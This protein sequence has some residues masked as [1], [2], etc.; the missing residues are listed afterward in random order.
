MG[1]YVGGTSPKTRKKLLDGVGRVLLIDEAYRLA[2]GQ[3]ESEAVNEMIQFLSQPSHQNNTVVI[4]AG[5][6][7]GMQELMGRPALSRIFQ[8][9]I[10]FENIPADDCIV[11]LAKELE[12]YGFSSDGG[13]LTNPQS[14]EHAAVKKLF[15]D[16]QLTLSWSN[17]RDVK[18]LAKQIIGRFLGGN[19]NNAKQT[20][21][22]S[23]AQI[24]F[25][26]RQMMVL[27]KNRCA[28]TKGSST[29]SSDKSIFPSTSHPP[30]SWGAPGLTKCAAANTQQAPLP[31]QS[32]PRTKI[33]CSANKR[34]KLSSD[35]SRA[36]NRPVSWSP[37]DFLIHTETQGPAVE[38]NEN[39][40]SANHTIVREHEV[41]YE[42]GV[43]DAVKRELREAKEAKN[44]KRS[45]IE[46]DIE[47]LERDK[48]TAEAV[49][50]EGK[51]V[52]S[53]ISRQEYDAIRDQLQSLRQ[54]LRKEER[55]QQELKKMGRCK[56]GYE[57]TQVAGGFRCEGG[58]HFVSD[59]ELQSR[60]L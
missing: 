37:K 36:P 52:L 32:I 2:N 57:W 38:I 4:L 31:L 54:S 33:E 17:A 34:V 25:C 46:V 3:Y 26:M 59:C 55:V 58:M 50:R 56:Y 11:L 1:E 20:R 21:T 41:K 19:S 7:A 10:T 51:G 14:P 24:E 30:P 35:D 16:M 44:V 45:Q 29:R 5:H 6:T 18:Y 43:S 23:L 22:L 48:E 53:A 12:R 39:C 49:Q 27:Q 9:E 60:L 40:Q 47:R 42:E 13:F 28:N 8:E 15:S